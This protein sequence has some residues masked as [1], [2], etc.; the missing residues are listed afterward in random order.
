MEDI[1]APRLFHGPR[2]AQVRQYLVAALVDGGDRLESG[3]VGHAHF[4]KRR[5]DAVRFHLARPDLALE[6][7]EVEDCRRRPARPGRA[8]LAMDDLLFAVL[9]VNL[10]VEL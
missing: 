1:I 3:P 2:Q 10:V 4:G 5:I 6:L 7:L 8:T 9:T